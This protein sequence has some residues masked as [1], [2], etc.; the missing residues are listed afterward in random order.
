M[1]F[2]VTVVAIIV[3][4]LSTSCKHK[5]EE[6]KKAAGADTTSFYPIADAINADI[7]EVNSTPYYIYKKEVVNGKRDS[8]P[9]NVAMF[10]Q[11]AEHF[12]KPDISDKK[13]KPNY[14]ESIFAD[15]TTQSI[16]FNYSTTNKELETQNVDVLLDETGQ[17]VK[18]IFIRKYFNYNDSTAIEQ[19]TWKPHESFQIN[20]AVMKKDGSENRHQTTIVWNGRNKG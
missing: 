8:T 18:N 4:F 12:L 3:C 14:K 19:L 9:A 17:K 10:N 13:L 20:R 16:T 6:N 11:L 1:K 5:S 2:L 7:K 15:Q